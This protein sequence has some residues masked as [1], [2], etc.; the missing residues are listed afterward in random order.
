M[1]LYV[2]TVLGVNIFVQINISNTD[3]K[4]MHPIRFQSP[5]V[6]LE[7]PNAFQSKSE[8]HW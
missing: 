6:S 4:L 8:K 7:L 1:R 5:L 3:Q 2:S